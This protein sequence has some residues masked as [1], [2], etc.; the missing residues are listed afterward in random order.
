ML[1]I[2]QFS[3]YPGRYVKPGFVQRYDTAFAGK[4]GF[5][6]GKQLA[7]AAEKVRKRAYINDIA[8]VQTVINLLKM[9]HKNYTGNIYTGG[10][11]TACLVA[12][13]SRQAF[14]NET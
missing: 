4:D 12:F 10:R 7:Y 3:H 6:G 2:T 11:Q 13:L 1:Q 9:F 8:F 14:F 5:Y